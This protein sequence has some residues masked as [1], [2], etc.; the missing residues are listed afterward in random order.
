MATIRAS[1]G[2]C[3]DIELT[4]VDVHVRVC[5]DT[6]EGAYSFR[7]PVCHM[8][9]VKT[10]ETRTIDLLVASGVSMETWYLPA[11][12]YEPRAGRPITHDDILDFHEVLANDDA[13]SDALDAIAGR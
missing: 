12:L 4:T 6:E 10:A 11:E 3:G 1:C 13:L 2:T 5:V 9:T 7:C 8:T